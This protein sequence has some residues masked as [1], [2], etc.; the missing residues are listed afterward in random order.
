MYGKTVVIMVQRH[1][2]VH[3]VSLMFGSDKDRRA[4]KDPKLP[5]SDPRD[6]HWESG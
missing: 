6:D 1:V 4:P 2:R 3:D 5:R